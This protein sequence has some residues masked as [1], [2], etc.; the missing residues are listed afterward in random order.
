MKI[1]KTL[2]GVVAIMLIAGLAIAQQGSVNP[3]DMWVNP[4]TDDFSIIQQQ[5]EDYYSTRDKGLESGYKHWKGCSSRALPLMER[6]TVR[7]S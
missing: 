5:V 7:Y 1:L 4:T 3:S 2:I 6:A